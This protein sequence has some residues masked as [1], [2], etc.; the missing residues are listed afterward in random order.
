MTSERL[1]LVIEWEGGDRITA[2]FPLPPAYP[3]PC[4]YVHQLGLLTTMAPHR[5]RATWWVQNHQRPGSAP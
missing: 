3:T 5:W 4:A 2:P 1:E